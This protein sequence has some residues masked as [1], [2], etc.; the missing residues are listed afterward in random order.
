[1]VMLIRL[2]RDQHA[3]YIRFALD[4]E[5]AEFLSEQ[6]GDAWWGRLKEPFLFLLINT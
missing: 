6:Q 3:N 1:M 5:E 4:A 2:E